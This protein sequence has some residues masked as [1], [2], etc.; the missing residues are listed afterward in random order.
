MMINKHCIAHVNT[1]IKN[2]YKVILSRNLISYINDAIESV[3]EVSKLVLVTDENVYSLYGQSVIEALRTLDYPIMFFVVPVGRKH[4]SLQTASEIFKFLFKNEADSYTLILNLGGGTVGDLGGLVSALFLRG[5]R[6]FHI[7]TTLLSQVDSSIGSK[8]SVNFGKH[9][10]SLTLFN[11]P[12]A[13]LSDPSLLRTLPDAEYRSG[14][15][16]I[17]KYAIVLDVELFEDIEYKPE[18]LTDKEQ[19]DSVLTRTIQKKCEIV[20]AD[21]L[22]HSIFRLYNYGHEIGHAIEVAYSYHDLRHGEAV[23]IGMQASA[24]LGVQTGQT[25][26][27]IL[28][29][30]TTILA[31]LGLPVNIPAELLNKHDP[32]KLALEL[33]I[34]LRKDKKCFLRDPQWVIP[35][36]LGHASYNV[37]VKE[38]LIS[39]CL[40]HVS[41]GSL[42]EI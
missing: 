13:V 39:E 2:N 28:K 34:L 30:Q 7:P 36:E 29:R 12:Y 16:E 6:Y 15:A 19:I 40:K 17:V 22:E 3:P 35:H 18:L 24:W 1:N 31:K 33:D 37:R 8:V 4:K 26:P 10:N 21:P 5:V 41:E 27:S 25:D 42:P 20:S 14:L 32:K 11:P 23:S 9:L 38:Q